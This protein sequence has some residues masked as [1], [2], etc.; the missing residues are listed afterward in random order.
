MTNKTRSRETTGFDNYLGKSAFA[1]LIERTAVSKMLFCAF[2]QPPNSSS[3]VNNFSFGNAFSYFSPPQRR[4]DG[5]SFSR[6]FPDLLASRDISGRLPPPLWCL[7]LDHF[8]DHRHG[9][10]CEDRLTRRDDF[11]F[12]FPQFIRCQQASFSGDRYIANPALDKGVSGAARARIQNF[13]V[14]IQCPNKILCF[15]LIVV[16]VMQRVAPCSRSSSVRHQSFSD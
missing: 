2:V 9:W 7:F 14:F 15:C 4:A 11:E 10:L 8:I 5:S 16:V 12:I 3:M 13:D 1:D 6:Q